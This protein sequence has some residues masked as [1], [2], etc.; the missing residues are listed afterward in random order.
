MIEAEN[1]KQKITLMI[2]MFS[3]I[4]RLAFQTQIGQEFKEIMTLAIDENI[5]PFA[6]DCYKALSI[7]NATKQEEVKS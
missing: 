1:D 2:E 4:E 5:K 6:R 7:N 3:Q